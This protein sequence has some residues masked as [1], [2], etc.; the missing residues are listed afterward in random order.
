MASEFMDDFFNKDP[1][2]AGDTAEA[3]SAESSDKSLKDR[4]QK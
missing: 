2:A 3:N 4:V 1:E